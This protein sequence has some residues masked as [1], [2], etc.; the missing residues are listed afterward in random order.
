MK[1]TLYLIPA[2]IL[3]M[4]SCAFYSGNISSGGNPDCP[5]MEIATAQAEAIYIIG[6]GGNDRKSLIAEAKNKLYSKYA[7]RKDIKITNFSADFRTNFFIIYAKTRVTVSADVFN[8]GIKTDYFM[9]KNQRVEI[10]N[11]NSINNLND[12]TNSINNLNDT[13]TLVDGYI[14]GDSVLFLATEPYGV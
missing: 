14:P 9:E 12:N 13:T 7:N 4:S 10:D 11:T 8:C 5:V 2:I 1:S 3:L 6:I